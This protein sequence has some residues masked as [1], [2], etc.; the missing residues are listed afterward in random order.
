MGEDLSDIKHDARG[1]ENPIALMG[2]TRQTEK[3][4]NYFE[5]NSELKGR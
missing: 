2:K 1:Q 4:G 3:E 5:L